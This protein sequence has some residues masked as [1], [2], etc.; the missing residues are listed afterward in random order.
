MNAGFIGAGSGADRRRRRLAQDADRG[1][2]ASKSRTARPR[3]AA[4]SQTDHAVDSSAAPQPLVAHPRESMIPFSPV[5]IASIIAAGVVLWM[6]MLWIGMTAGSGDSAF[7]EILSL[8]HRRLPRFFSTICLLTATQ[9]SLLILWY[10]IRS[11]KDFGGRYR[12]WWLSSMYWGLACCCVTTD[13]HLAFARFVQRRWTIEM[14]QAETLHWL[15]PASITFLALHRLVQLDMRHSRPSRLAWDTTWWCAVAATIAMLCPRALVSAGNEPL[16]FAGTTTL[17]HLMTV[18]ALLIHARFVVHITNECAPKKPPRIM[19]A[20]HSAHA[21]AERLASGIP[22]PKFLVRMPN[23]LK[24]TPGE[25]TEQAKPTA[26]VKPRK[27]EP[28]AAKAPA[29]PAAPT[30]PAAQEELPT[31]TRSI[32]PSAPQ[33]RIDPPHATAPPVSQSQPMDDE[34]SDSENDDMGDS[35]DVSQ[36]SRKERRRLKKAQRASRRG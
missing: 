23:F 11:R 35:D 19:R 33:V 6:G 32:P 31:R 15:I 9:L 5:R 25:P 14:W 16:L 20:I 18:F 22:K 3:S 2:T 1:A 28:V 26:Q 4:R 21:T 24:R 30:A 7:K 29:K 10:R 12:V 8:E 34:D 17:W 36:L 27:P 13:L